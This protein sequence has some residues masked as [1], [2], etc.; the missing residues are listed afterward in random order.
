MPI[1]DWTRVTAGTFHDFHH[2]WL[3]EIRNALN[4]GVLPADF[5]AQTEQVAG[6]LNPDVLTLQGG[7]TS[8]GEDGSGPRGATAVADVPPRMRIRVEAETD[9]LTRRKRAL[10][11]R[12]SSGDQIVAFLEIISPGNKGAR[13][14]FRRFVDRAAGLVSEGYHLLLLDLLPPGPRDPQ[15][16]HAAVWEE[17]CGGY[18]PPP[19][20]PL[21]LASYDAG[22]P[23]TAWVEPVAVGDV[24]PDVPLFLAHGWYVN[25][26][27]EAT[28]QAAYRGVPQRW[29]AVLEAPPASPGNLR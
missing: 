23:P 22:Y 15:G 10:I 17:L 20:K 24:L 16:V 21:T 11:I 12:H 1:H 25:V 19:D 27:L 26:P 7:D 8:Q 3:V 6:E 14:A 18:T 9:A 29:K 2:A 4:G 13:H 5:Y 28:Y